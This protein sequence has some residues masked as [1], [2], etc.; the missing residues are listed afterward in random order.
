[1]MRPALLLF[2][3]LAPVLGACSSSPS[4]EGAS[5]SRRDGT[6]A[7]AE[8]ARIE[9]QYMT[10]G[11]LAAVLE[12]SFR[13]GLWVRVENRLNAVLVSGDADTVQAALEI[14]AKLDVPPTE[15]GE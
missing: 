14:A 10:A 9:M 7:G 12:H 11:D 6:Q 4:D 5:A 8:V 13:R 3:V 2:L 1:M 15:P